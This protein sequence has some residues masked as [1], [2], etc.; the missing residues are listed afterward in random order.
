[1]VCRIRHALE[2]KLYDYDTL[3]EMRAEVQP[4][5]ITTGA[6]TIKD[7]NREVHTQ[8][9]C[10][11]ICGAKVPNLA[12]QVGEHNTSDAHVALAEPSPNHHVQ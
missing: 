12:S 4:L 11:V 1:M 5:V 6:N 10:L 7:E 8:D 3:F 9:I 2:R